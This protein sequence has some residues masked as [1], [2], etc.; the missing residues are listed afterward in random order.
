MDALRTILKEVKVVPRA[1]KEVYVKPMQ[2]VIKDLLR[3]TKRLDEYHVGGNWWGEY[4]LDNTTGI[5]IEL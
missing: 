5:I 4:K 1:N 2:T 3:A